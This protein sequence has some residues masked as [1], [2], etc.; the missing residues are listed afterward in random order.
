M[1]S[2]LSTAFLKKELSG[3]ESHSKQK[4]IFMIFRKPKLSITIQTNLYFGDFLDLQLDLKSNLFRF[5]KTKMMIYTHSSKILENI[6][7]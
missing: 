4:V 5:Y 3:P 1:L 2:K 6:L 7:K